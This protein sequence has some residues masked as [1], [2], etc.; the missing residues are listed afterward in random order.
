LAIDGAPNASKV[1]VWRVTIQTKTSRFDDRLGKA[2]L[3]R[4][5]VRQSGRFRMVKC[6][7]IAKNLFGSSLRGGVK[8]PLPRQRNDATATLHGVV[9]DISVG[10]VA[11]LP[12]QPSDMSSGGATLSGI[13]QT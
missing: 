7:P 6:V 12:D 4:T 3:Q 10:A 11:R 9:F 13:G 2:A 5:P 1:N 8:P